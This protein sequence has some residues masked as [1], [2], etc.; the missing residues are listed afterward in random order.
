M[1]VTAR[2]SPQA[3]ARKKKMRRPRGLTRA[4]YTWGSVITG[5]AAWQLF[6]MYV[7]RNSLF[8]ATPSQSFVSMA[9]LWSTGTL[10]NAIVVSGEEFIVG[11]LIASVAG[12]IIGLFTAT[13]DRV[14][15][16]LSPWVSGL[17]ATPIIA[18]A[19][20]LILWF[21]VG[22]WSK[23]AVVISLVI[24]PM[25]ISTEAGIRHT[26]QQLV[27]AARSFGATQMQIFT[28]VALP[29]ALPLILAG[30]RLGVGRGLIGVVVGELA[31]ARA[32]IGYLINEASQVFNM[33]QLFAG[34]IVLAAAGIFLTAGFERLERVLVPWKSDA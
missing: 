26:D 30:L 6:G 3:P 8:L 9:K 31:G 13:F 23:I 18:V 17:Y 27:E 20:L 29:S 21:G 11:F 15:L 12:I 19:P 34:V 14:S 33:P 5:L 32:G 4:A 7:I 22:I 28:K 16:V 2:I 24:F 10:Q 1:A 25:I